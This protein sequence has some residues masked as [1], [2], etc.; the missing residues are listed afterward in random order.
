MAK[1]TWTSSYAT[2]PRDDGTPRRAGS[3]GK[4]LKRHERYLAFNEPGAGGRFRIVLSTHAYPSIDNPPSNAAC[5]KAGFELLG[6]IDFE[7]PPGNPLR[8]NEWRIELT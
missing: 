1:P 3:E 7:Y 6:E 4:L 8:C 2:T 5:R